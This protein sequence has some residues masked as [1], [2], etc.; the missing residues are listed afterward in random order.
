MPLRDLRC[1]RCSTQ[2]E[3]LVSASLGWGAVVKA[4]CPRVRCKG[5]CEVIPSG[6]VTVLGTAIPTRIPR[7]RVPVKPRSA[8]TRDKLRDVKCNSCASVFEALCP[9]DLGFGDVARVECPQCD[10]RG[11]TIQITVPRLSVTTKELLGKAEFRKRMKRR[12]REDTFADVARDPEKHGFVANKRPSKIWR[13][14]LKASR[15]KTASK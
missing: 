13:S 4:A 11:A 1:L 7:E 6:G 5:D 8:H 9:S 3:A 15:P 2:H 10:R 12:C 14:S